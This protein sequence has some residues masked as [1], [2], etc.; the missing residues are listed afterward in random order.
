M[1]G[2]QAAN[3]F[4]EKH[5]K[6]NFWLILILLVFI[7]GC[8][9]GTVET[10]PITTLAEPTATLSEVLVRT[11]SAPD[12]SMTANDY[13]QAWQNEDFSA[14]YALLTSVSRDA[15]DEEEFI[16]KHTRVAVEAALKQPAL[17]YE[18][19]SALVNPYNAQ[20]S[21]R[22]TMHSILI[23]D[24]TARESVMNLSLE[25]GQWRVQWDDGLILAD[26][27]GGNYLRMEY[28][29]PSRANI[30]DSQGRALVA[31]SDAVAVG[32]DAGQLAAEK[33]SS[34]LNLLLRMSEG[35]LRPEILQPRLENYRNNG[36]Y[37]PI[38]DF[39]T[40]V[41]SRFE[42]ALAAFPEVIM[43]SFRSRYYFDGG[44][45]SVAPHVTGYMSLIQVEEVDQYQRLGYRQ[46]ER[47]GRSGLEQWGEPYLAGQRGGALYV[48]NPEGKIITKLAETSPLP[49]Q[50]I[51]TT[52]DKNLQMKVQ[53]A[54]GNFLGAIVVLERDTGRVLAMASSPSFNP[55]LFEAT[56]FNR[57]FLIN[58]VFDPVTTPTLNRATQGQYPLGSVFK[59][60]T[61]AA[62][63]ESGLYTPETVYNCGYLFT[64]L[65]GVELRDWTYER[66]LQDGRTPP[67]GPLNLP[68]GL[69]RSCNPYFFHIG[70]DLYNQG[71]TTA[72]SD[73]ARGF[74][75]SSL[76]GIELPEEKAG[77]IPDP[78]S[79]TD[80]TNAAIGQGNTLVTPLQ[81][82]RFIAA[83]G[84]GGTLYRPSVIERIAPPD[85]EASYEF[86][87]EA[88]GSLPIT[89]ETRQIIHE[90]MVRVVEDPRG[91]ARHRFANVGV[92]IAGKTGT[93]ET[94]VAPHSWF[95]GY[96]F[97]ERE[98]KPDIAIAV[99][100]ENRGEGSDYAAPIFRRVIEI[101]FSGQPLTQY[102]WES[103]IG[104]VR[105]PTPE[106]TDTPIPSPTDIPES[107]SGSGEETPSE[108]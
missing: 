76:T 19:R 103:Q 68:E 32:V 22:V 87:P 37:L 9:R 96:T 23:G 92:R 100:V 50:A 91:T 20:I 53:E 84:N 2:L 78:T 34:L 95:A 57:Q 25:N 104:V 58:Q 1:P 82:A 101:Y 16:R 6:R 73:M 7:S 40:E 21:Y 38:A 39:S 79:Q 89:E 13:L 48:V 98:G 43:Q 77:F 69:M 15:I 90:A 62:G 81:V 64:E 17:D 28:R 51:Y 70:L 93:A 63:L 97:S 46:D 44:L 67:S 65:Q 66:F 14:M 3:R 33:D 4:E 102:W 55:N 71:L 45:V 59:I 85:G 56:N 86:A 30:Y 10:Q 42:S 74:G 36:W 54:L 52:L 5:M 75:L 49:S 41:I 61:M 35:Q 47:V 80:A 12:P 8:Q 106:V 60:I 18:I 29:I 11:T 94:G 72:I 99:L 107:E 83:L 108:P 105:T 88:Q 27:S 24:F 31:Q 26:L